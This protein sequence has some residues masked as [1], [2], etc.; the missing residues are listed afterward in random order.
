MTLSL[1]RLASLN[2]NS[3]KRVCG[4]G[5]DRVF[6]SAFDSRSTRRTGPASWPDRVPVVGGQGRDGRGAFP[7][8]WSLRRTMKRY[9]HHSR[10]G[11]GVPRALVAAVVLVHGDERAARQ[12]LATSEACAAQLQQVRPRPARPRPAVWTLQG[13]P[14]PAVWTLQVQRRPC[15]WRG[16]CRC[17][18]PLPGP[19]L[20]RV[21]TC[22]G[23]AA[24]RTRAGCGVA[25]WR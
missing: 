16:I 4:G 15:T 10:Q 2:S 5:R 7:E 1:T 23:T 25:Y 17:A 3:L 18:G 8:P 24:A 13:L 12:L 22:R 6:D 11:R 9:G 20:G 21:L 14:R 19:S